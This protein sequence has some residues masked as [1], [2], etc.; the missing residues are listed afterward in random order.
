ME[1]FAKLGI[2]WRL[3]IAQLVNF[4]ILFSALTFLLYKPLIGVLEKR[5]KKIADSLKDAERIGEELR[6]AQDKSLAILSEARGEAGKVVAVAQ[7]A[8]DRVRSEALD[9]AR[10][11]VAALVANGKNQLIA[12]RDA[13]VNDVRVVAAELIAE[14]TQKVIGE[15]M[16]DAKDKHLIEKILNKE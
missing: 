15:K 5:Q 16:N 1:L 6:S 8:A 2:D 11:E 13:M 10:A 9:K 7:A 3:L 14:A 4:V 12:E